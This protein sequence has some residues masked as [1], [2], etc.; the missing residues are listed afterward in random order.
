MP[1][2]AQ[3]WV[4]D[5]Y[6]KKTQRSLRFCGFSVDNGRQKKNKK[7]LKKN[8]KKTKKKQKKVKKKTKKKTK[9]KETQDA[10]KGLRVPVG[11]GR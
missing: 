10:A 8:K 4:G 11:D 2:G 5:G 3:L 6:K 1:T 7:K 9:K